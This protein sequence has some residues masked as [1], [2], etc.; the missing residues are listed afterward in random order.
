MSEPGDEFERRFSQRYAEYL[1]DGVG[2]LDTKQVADGATGSRRRPVGWLRTAIVGTAAVAGVAAV[3]LVALAILPKLT[4]LVGTPTRSPQASIVATATMQPTLAPT[5]SATTSQPVAVAW[6]TVAPSEAAVPSS[7][8]GQD[9]AFWTLDPRLPCCGSA[10]RISTSTGSPAG[11]VD[12]PDVGISPEFLP[13]PAGPAGSRVLYVV[14]DGQTTAHLRVADTRTGV[15]TVLTS[16]SHLVARL[17]LDPSGSTAYYLL[18]DRRTSAF[19]GLWAISTNGGQPRQLIASQATIALVSLAAERTYAPQLAVSSDGSWIVVASCQSS[20]CEFHAT[21]PDG[22]AETV[23]AS[24]LHAG[25]TIVGIAGSLLIGS[26]ECSSATCDGFALDLRTGERWPLAGADQPFAPTQLIAGPRGPLV[27]G[28]SVDHGQGLWNVE[29]MDLTSGARSNVFQAAFEP[30]VTSVRLAAGYQPA[31]VAGAELPP[32]WFLISRFT[33]VAALLPPDYSA[34]TVG[35]ALETTLPF[36]KP[37]N[38]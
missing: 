13:V 23:D 6:P 9:F 19:R 10:L 11:T 24:S 3:G 1:G 22:T 17:A 37:S 7:L 8:D 12:I 35:T 2:R 26:S 20:G 33:N 15:D 25:D 32:G 31:G 28:Q 21:H 38:P 30:G 29:A 34:A 27:I 18:F 36:M 14:N 4:G 5:P 16:T